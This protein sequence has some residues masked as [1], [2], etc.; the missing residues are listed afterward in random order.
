MPRSANS[1]ASLKLGDLPPAEAMAALVRFSFDYL[2][3]HPDFIGMLN[4]ENAHGAL[5]R[6]QLQRRSARPTR[7]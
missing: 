6:A 2:A 7:R 5:V 4:H 1:S 3:R